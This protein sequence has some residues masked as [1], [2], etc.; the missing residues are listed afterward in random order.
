MNSKIISFLVLFSALV[1]HAVDA[2]VVSGND[3]VIFRALSDELRENMN[4]LHHEGFSDPFYIAYHFSDALAY[5]GSA[6]SGCLLRSDLNPFRSSNVRLMVGNYELNDENFQDYSSM[7]NQAGYSIP[8][9]IENDYWSIRRSYW[10]MTDGVYRSARSIYRNKIKLLESGKMPDG[11]ET[12]P[13]FSREKDTVLIMTPNREKVCRETYDSL[14]RVYSTYADTGVDSLVTTVSLGVI[15]TD[16]YYVNSEGTRILVP[17]DIATLELDIMGRDRT[18]KVVHRSFQY[19][20]DHLSGL[21]G[22]EEIGL[23][24]DSLKQMMEKILSSETYTEQYT[25]PVLF[26]GEAASSLFSGFIESECD[27]L[28]ASRQ[29]LA[30]DNRGNVYLGGFSDGNQYSLGQRVLPK[31]FS[32]RAFTHTDS[33]NGVLLLGNFEI[34]AQ[35]VVPPDEITLVENGILVNQLNG[36][37]P[38]KEVPASNGHNRLGIGAPVSFVLPGILEVSIDGPLKREEELIDMLIEQAKDRGLDYAFIVRN[39]MK[40]SPVTPLILY[41]IDVSSR[42]EEMVR[43]TAMLDFGEKNLRSIPAF[44]N[45]RT[46][47]NRMYGSGYSGMM[48]GP[49]IGGMGAAAMGFPVTY[50]IP[51]GFLMDEVTFSQGFQSVSVTEP[52]VPMPRAMEKSR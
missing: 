7:M 33:L 37:T 3:T 18:H 44:S 32:I 17:V 49:G 12:V 42:E 9:P 5:G 25:G 28:S 41:K 38:T 14:L 4:H 16:H 43:M 39:T 52:V 47:S 26:L 45:L 15:Y 20:A 11:F 50:L 34:D 13:D 35:G 19:L 36:R 48:G 10:Q 24:A 6:E 23:A 29:G 51:G 22:P 40:V 30:A 46:I 1:N 21:P 31:H 27:F 8:L 2:Q